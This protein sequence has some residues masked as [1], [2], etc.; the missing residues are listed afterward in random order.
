MESL[1]ASKIE[2]FK[3]KPIIVSS[4]SPISEIIG[5]LKNNDAY[6]VFI[7]GENKVSTVTMREI[8]KASD[9]SNRRASSLMFYVSKLSPD[10]TVG[11]AARL[12]NDYRLRALPIVKDGTIEGAVTTQSLCQA[13]V[14]VR[15]FREVKISKIMTKNPLTI[16]EDDSVSKARS[17]MLKEGIDHL[18]V[19]DSG[20]LRG[21]LLSNHIV[22]SMFPREGLE[23]GAFVSKPSSYLD[24]K[25]SGLMDENV[26]VCDP[27]ERALT[28]LERMTKQRKTYAVVKL[29]HEIQGIATYRDFIVFLAKPEEVDI[30]VYIVGLPDD[31]FEAGLAEIKFLRDAKTL[32]KSFPK[33]EEICSTIKTED[34]FGD[35]RRYEVNVSIRSAGKIYTYTEEGWDLPSIFDLIADKMKRLL[36]KKRKRRRKS[37]RKIP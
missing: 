15:E 30:P 16:D 23:K 35:R 32:C 37:V 1:K 29:W 19:L 2:N 21:I 31:P 17:L 22:F 18:P 5:I 7:Q 9:I 27:K 12:M 14:S 24:L 4:T 36:T 26:L 8:L 11:K 6:E 28:V 33:I 25:V 3:S 13:I 10:D 34:L 20:E